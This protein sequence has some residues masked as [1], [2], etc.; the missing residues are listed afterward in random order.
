MASRSSIS[1]NGVWKFENNDEGW[2]TWGTPKDM[3]SQEKIE[4]RDFVT[5]DESVG[6]NKKGSL[7]I[8]DNLERLNCY[9]ISPV[10]ELETTQK[11]CLTGHYKATTEVKPLVFLAC[12]DAGGNILGFVQEP[13]AN[14]VKLKMEFT[15]EKDGWVSFKMMIP[16]AAFV[17]TGTKGQISVKPAGAA[18]TEGFKGTLWLSDLSLQPIVSEPIAMEEQMNRGFKD[19]PAEKVGGWTGQG[20]FDL[21][22]MKSGLTTFLGIPFKIVNPAENKGRSIIALHQNKTPDYFSSVDVPLEG[23]S[24]DRIYLLQ[25]AAWV[26]PGKEPIAF[27]DFTYKNGNTSSQEI[28]VGQH[29]ADW[30]GGRV[31]EGGVAIPMENMNTKKDRV[32]LYLA[33]IENPHPDEP[34]QSL[35]FR[36][37][38]PDPYWL[39]LGA[40]GSRGMST[41]EME[42]ATKRSTE[43]WKEF[44]PSLRPTTPETVSLEFLLDAPAGKHGFL[45]VDKG[46]FKFAD[47]TPVRFWGMNVHATYA[48]FPS[49]AEAD[50]AVETM[51]R[52]GCNMVRLH[53]PDSVLLDH[54]RGAAKTPS[55]TKEDWEKFDYFFCKLKEKGIY[56]LLDSIT[57]LSTGLPTKGGKINSPE[58]YGRDH[59][60]WA[61]VDP[62]IRKFGHEFMEM[63]LSHVNSITGKKMVEDPALALVLMINEQSAFWK[64]ASAKDPKTIP[65]HYLAVFKKD[66][67]EWL[68]TRYKDRAGLAKAWE[69][70]GGG[71]ALSN[72]E[73][74]ENGSVE[75]PKIDFGT[76]GA[77]LK[78]AIDPATPA[79]LRLR[80][81]AVVEYLKMAQE[82]FYQE[83]GDHAKQIGLK[84]PI[85]GT[86]IIFDLA[87]LETMKKFGVTSQN[88][89]WELPRIVNGEIQQGNVPQPCSNPMRDA[90]QEGHEMSVWATRMAGAAVTSSEL[91]SM[92]PQ[93]WR[94]SHLMMTG[95][96]AALQDADAIIQFAFAG[97]WNYTWE[98]MLNSKNI[99][100]PTV[101]FNDPSV[102]A[103]FVSGA[104][105]F[106][107][108]DVKPAQKL[109]RF[110]VDER[111]RLA[112]EGRLRDD[113]FPMNY[114]TYVSRLDFAFP[115]S[116]APGKPDWVLTDR[117]S[118]GR[119]ENEKMAI[120][121]DA[122][123]K[124]KGILA[125]DVGLQDG[126]LVS[127]T[128]EVRRDWKNQL[129]TVNTPLSQGFA[130]FPGKDPI[131]LKDVQ[132]QSLVPYATFQVSSLDKTPLSTAK[133]MFV[134]AVARSDNKDTVFNFATKKEMPFGG[135]RGLDYS[136][137]LNSLGPVVIEPTLLNIQMKGKKFRLT[138]LG[139][140][141]AKIKESAVEFSGSGTT[142]I[143]I[144]KKDFSVWYLLERLDE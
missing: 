71:T 2:K 114:L 33:S 133:R 103:S 91:D 25:S 41:L 92:W 74:P 62:E 65:P 80:V 10:F 130:G 125:A 56:L 113:S 104:F 94:S 64:W 121:L 108:G 144:G 120:A 95:A 124:E 5:W 51:A 29:V 35:A 115:E 139:P 9:A 81:Q 105:L 141:M 68:V 96:T 70:P 40:T 135:D 111:L 4:V 106:L 85:I 117:G 84:V 76:N 37:A 72:E 101:E 34:I 30:F 112:C 116:E 26:I 44:I 49:K 60:A 63:L 59:R 102:L 140:D 87:E 123:L 89:Y 11:Y 129:F 13:G 3:S 42:I 118:G 138:P 107:R 109:V 8:T 78:V 21:R 39:I 23:Q 98:M 43:A 17:A 31:S 57:G 32:F 100:N 14:K 79:P 110:Q 22:G 97:G 77:G 6:F 16:P 128:G 48:M 90:G 126:A 15:D 127:D 1:E 24:Y 73:D 61:Y 18:D 55:V 75:V 45:K 47:E 12:M 38:K 136:A 86:N 132:V 46:H 134:V 50:L 54:N 143:E 52:Y 137:K 82:R 88:T 93:E 142:E 58:L 99:L 69:L 20:E 67:N 36:V 66:F 28:V 27:V 131:I 7:K 19:D 122:T 83:M 53:L 119:E